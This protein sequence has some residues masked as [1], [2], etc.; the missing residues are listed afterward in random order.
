MNICNTVVEQHTTL[1]EL[2]TK[3]PEDRYDSVVK[4]SGNAGEWR[5]PSLHD[6]SYLQHKQQKKVCVKCMI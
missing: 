4:L 2:N 3:Q 1:T 5:S 6:D